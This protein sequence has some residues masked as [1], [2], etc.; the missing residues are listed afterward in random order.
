MKNGKFKAVQIGGPSGGCLTEEHLDL[1]LDFESTKKIGAIIGSGGL[2][3][4]GD[5][6][7]HGRDRAL[8]HE[9]HQEGILR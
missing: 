1:P 8:L 7:M 5:D 2:V 3:V 6:T 4:M 9:L